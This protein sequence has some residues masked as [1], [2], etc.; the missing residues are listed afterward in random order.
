M[1][2]KKILAVLSALLIAGVT[3]SGAHAQV[4]NEVYGSVGTDGVG[5][6]YG[7]GISQHFGTR[8]EVSGFSYSHG[9]SAGDMHYDANL[10]LIHGSL[11]GDYFPAPSFFPIRLT[12]GVLV[13]ADQLSGNA[14]GSQGTYTFNGVTVPTQGES[15]HASLKFPAVRPYVGIGFGHNPNAKEGL[16]MAFDAGVAI[17]KPSVTFDVPQNIASAAGAQNVAAEEQNLRSKASKFPVYP[18]VKVSLTYRFF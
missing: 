9:F 6:G 7:Y 17:G 11:L 15:V 14:T 3:S 1:A 16:S 12:V 2:N 4:R 5:L 13:G 18:I 10:R 8:V